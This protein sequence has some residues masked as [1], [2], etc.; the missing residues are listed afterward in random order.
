MGWDCNGINVNAL[1]YREIIKT[2]NEENIH[3]NKI[4]IKIENKKKTEKNPTTKLSEVY[5]SRARSHF[6]HTKC[7]SMNK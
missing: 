2:K 6:Q 5:C 7:V 3:R 4:I 1:V